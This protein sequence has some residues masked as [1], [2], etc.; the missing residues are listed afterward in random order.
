ME[1]TQFLI[2]KNLDIAPDVF[3]LLIMLDEAHV[4]LAVYVIKENVRYWAEGL[5]QYL[6]FFQA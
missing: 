4:E 5:G 6:Q 2:L 1:I 3:N